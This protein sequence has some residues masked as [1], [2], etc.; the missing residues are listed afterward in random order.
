MNCPICGSS[1]TKKNG[2]YTNQQQRVQK[3]FCKGCSSDYTGIPATYSTKQEHR[4][5]LNDPIV[6]LYQKGLS[7]REIASQLHC[8]RTTV[9]RKLKKYL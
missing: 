4:P 2:W 6:E 9:Q 7:Q 3:Y 8:S 5:D 1:K